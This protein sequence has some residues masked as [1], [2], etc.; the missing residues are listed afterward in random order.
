[1]IQVQSRY[2]YLAIDPKKYPHILYKVKN[3]VGPFFIVVKKDKKF[4]DIKCRFGI[5]ED[6][7]CSIDWYGAK[8]NVDYYGGEVRLLTFSDDLPLKEADFIT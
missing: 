2:L 4:M 8:Y 5:R 7:W 1:M 6:V 3:R